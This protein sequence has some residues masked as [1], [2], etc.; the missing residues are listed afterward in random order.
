MSSGASLILGVAGAVV[1]GF[2]GGP[3][4]AQAG[5]AIGSYVGAQFAPAQK[6]EGPR[7]TDLK[8][9]GVEYGQAIPYVQGSYRVS[10]Q[11]W[12]SSD[13][14]EIVTITSNDSGGK[15][16]GPEV[17]ETTYTYEV[18]LL[19]GLTDN[20]IAGVGRIWLNGKLVWTNLD[21]DFAGA[22]Q[23][24]GN[25]GGTLA[26]A[27][28]NATASL[29]ASA[30]TMHWNRI[31]VYTG[32]SSQQPDPTY[33]AA[34]GTA[35]A[36]AYRDRGSVFIEGLQLGGSGALPNLTF[37]VV[38][39]A[40]AG[41]VDA[42]VLLQARFADN[43]SEDES[44]YQATNTNTSVTFADN[45]LVINGE[46]GVASNV[47]WEGTQFSQSDGPFAVTIEAFLT[48]GSLV[49]FVQ[50]QLLFFYIDLG[51]ARR[52]I[53]ITPSASRHLHYLSVS[54]GSSDTEGTH[55]LPS[56]KCHIAIVIPN[57]NGQSACDHRVYINGVL[58]ITANYPATP[59]QDSGWR[60][61]V[62]TVSG[63]NTDFTCHGIRVKTGEVY[64][65]S[66]FT[67]PA[68][69]DAW[70]DVDTTATT[71]SPSPENLSD[72]VSRLCLRAGLSA[73]QIDLSGISSSPS[74]LVRGMAIA[75]VSST[76][77]VLEMLMSA[78]FFEAKVS[79]KIYFVDRGGSSVVTIPHD[80]MGA[81]ESDDLPETFE[82][83]Q[84]NDIELPAQV[85]ITYANYLD[86]YQNDTQMSDRIVSAVERSVATVQLPLSLIPSEAKAI[87][88]TMVTD[89][90]VS[91]V[92]APVRILGEYSYVEPTDIVTP[93]DGDGNTYRMR[94]VEVQD[95]YPLLEM[96]CVIDYA[97]TLISSGTTSEDYGPS[98]DVSEPPDA[99]IELMDIPILRDVDDGDDIYA[100]M[101]GAITEWPGGSL[102]KS[103]DS[104]MASPER[105]ARFTESAVF[106]EASELGDWD[107]GRWFDEVN[108]VTVDVGVGTLSSSTRAAV[109]NDA[110]INA[111]LI[112]NEIIQFVTATLQSEG[113]YVL[114]RLLRGSRGTEWAMTG[115]ASGERC[116]LLRMRGLRRIE[117]AS[118]ELGVTRYYAGVTFGR[119]L[120]TGLTGS[121]AE[122]ES[123]LNTGV[124]LKPFS[125]VRVRFVRESN[126]D[127]TIT[128]LKR[129]RLGVR[130]IGSLGI[131]VPEDDTDSW[132]CDI[133]S[134][135]GSPQT[136]YRTL[137][138]T[139][140]DQVVSFTYTTAQQSTDFGSP[141][142]TQITV[143]MY[144]VNPTVGRGYAAFRTSAI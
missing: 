132:V 23:Q 8:I 27:V 75:Q 92:S 74:K 54:P 114:S 45:T 125:P 35:N 11:I 47:T 95:S 66:S 65:G 140:S 97:G 38:T 22:L 6:V 53:T 118:T 99:L 112:G 51:D 133:L 33:E 70:P 144:G 107:G 18:D 3:T 116:V 12:W 86:D 135:E 37:E 82:L 128:G 34:V 126:G 62:G 83:V 121:P 72:V 111:M 26:Q 91:N 142:P 59:N 102:F 4:G 87:S 88:D 14:R 41:A 5:W 103:I 19:I 117:L 17:E 64:T 25:G 60:V 36:V 134:N 136:T 61:V 123:L 30:N 50:H 80:D 94:V 141:T 63:Q 109:L 124:A 104:A 21:P 143:G 56:T 115:H 106:G 31:T 24:M 49:D 73:S 20:E 131:N 71:L 46:A 9:T 39:R 1:G 57:D 85:S 89:Q 81:T 90:Y 129:S 76:R 96:E 93:T 137:T 40:D 100:A 68:S 120:S 48:V 44:S 79:D 55:D 7:L 130:M 10:G 32:S 105:V 113:V 16:G 28:E 13:R 84:G 139:V 138:G 77:S 67:P 119:A 108:T 43:A 69:E 2:F 78:Y 58:D 98:V 122:G 15:G 52:I 29:T 110:T 101:K 42:T 127:I